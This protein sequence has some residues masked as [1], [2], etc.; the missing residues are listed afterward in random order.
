MSSTP[1][2]SATSPRPPLRLPDLRAADP[3]SAGHVLDLIRR[4]GGLTRAEI[5]E[6]TGL[7]RSTVTGRLATLESAGHITTRVVEAAGRGRPASRSI[8]R[9]E[10]GAL[11][12]ADAGATGVRTALTDLA[13]TVL[14]ES[15][16][17]LDIT[18]GPEAWLTRLAELFAGLL[19]DAGCD[20]AFV[21]GV[22]LSLPGPVDFASGTVV[23][24]PIMTGWDGYPIRQWFARLFE[25][26]VVVDKDANVLATG[27][28]ATAHPDASSMLMLKI[29]TGIGSGII[30]NGSLYRGEDGA[31]G[32]IGHIQLGSRDGRAPLPCR[33]GNE[34]CVEAYASGW[35]LV[36]DLR[37]AGHD[38]DGVRDLVRL[39]QAGDPTVT[40]MTR[41]AGRTIGIAIADAV[42]L[43]NPAVVVV[44][45]DLG[46]AAANLVAGIRET[47]YAR[48]LPLA[49]RRLEIT[50]TTLGRSAGL[51]GLAKTVTDHLYAPARID[52]QLGR[53]SVNG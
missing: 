18:I 1:A 42:S 43:L 6:V 26:P 37:A 41:E 29:A 25:C 39:V 53:E 5:L 47:V 27:E 14:G 9:H 35:A 7:A 24:P 48:C 32:D 52:E 4:S 19:A 17:A 51:I 21:R 33:C 46:D 10:S 45:G 20:S 22:G 3:G 16:V 38:V 12:L 11:L 36:R 23:Q 13:G 8:F 31:A 28:Y 2:R 40:A 15:T 49:T 44:G 30:A 50:S 34:G